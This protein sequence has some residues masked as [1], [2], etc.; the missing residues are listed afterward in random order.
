[1]NG[2]QKV[3]EIKKFPTNLRGKKDELKR[4]SYKK[5][6]YNENSNIE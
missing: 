3:P 6:G 2:V 4:S 1:M 5:S